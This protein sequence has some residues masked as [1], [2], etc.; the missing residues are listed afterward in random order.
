MNSRW[1]GHGLGADQWPQVLVVVEHRRRRDRSPRQQPPGAVQVGHD[2]VQQLGPLHHAGLEPRP[3]ALV[4]DQRQAGRAARAVARP[5]ASGCGPG[6]SVVGDGDRRGRARGV[7]DV[8][9]L[10]QPGDL[11]LRVQQIRVGELIADRRP[12]H[13]QPSRTVPSAP[14]NSSNTGSRSTADSPARWAR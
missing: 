12:A 8:V 1:L 9:V 2:R 6:R 10:Q 13:D 11:A 5:A 7:G 3:L 14:A 4:E